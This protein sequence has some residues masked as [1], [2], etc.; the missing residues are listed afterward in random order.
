MVCGCTVQEGVCVVVVGTRLLTLVFSVFEARSC[1]ALNNAIYNSY[2][3]S[4]CVSFD[5]YKVHVIHYG[6]HPSSSNQQSK[7]ARI[8]F[9]RPTQTSDRKN[10]NINSPKTGLTLSAR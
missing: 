6:S 5:I 7:R 8:I 1:R 10:S 4:I 9:L 2:T 3:L